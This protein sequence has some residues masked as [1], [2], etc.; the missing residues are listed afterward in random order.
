MWIDLAE[1][2]TAQQRVIDLCEVL[3]QTELADGALRKSNLMWGS[4]PFLLDY[5]QPAPYPSL[6]VRARNVRFAGKPEV[7][8]WTKSRLI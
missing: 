3:R 5:G 7:G 4:K 2:T 8:T 6:T 1:R